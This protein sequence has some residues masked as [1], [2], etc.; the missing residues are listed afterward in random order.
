MAYF[1]NSSEGDN[2]REECASCKYGEKP[3]PI[4]L[5]QFNYNY[6]A[7][8]NKIAR[9]ILDDL[10]SD[11]G[12]CLMKEEFKTDFFKDVNQTKLF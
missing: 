7:C 5:V 12:T 6:S 9:S 3:C 11:D 8:N 1:A 4:F 10:I 2:F